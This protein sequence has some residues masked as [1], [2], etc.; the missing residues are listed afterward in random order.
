MEDITDIKSLFLF[1]E[2]TAIVEAGKT[3]LFR[4]VRKESYKLIPSLGRSITNEKKQ[5][6][7]CTE[8]LLLKLFKQKCYEFVKEHKDND[9]ALLSIAQHHGLP[10]RLLDWSKNPLVALYFAVKDEFGE[11]EEPEDSVIYIYS[12]TNL[13]DLERE[14]PPFSI[15]SV[16]RY[17]PKYW[18]PRIVS[19]SGVFTVHP[20]PLEPFKSSEIK[21]IK[22]KS[23]FRKDIKRYI[24]KFDINE[25]TLFPDLDGISS[26]IKWLRTNAF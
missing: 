1:L 21:T 17:I 12:P 18:N 4:G 6:D 2:E 23:K 3:Q 14:F 8:K 11:Y 24:N 5:F 22:I 16:E 13:V 20:K 10:T 9:L 7:P 25:G 15:T 19:Q 26:H